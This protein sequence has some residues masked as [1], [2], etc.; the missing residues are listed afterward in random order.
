MQ[1]ASGTPNLTYISSFPRS[2]QSYAGVGQIVS[3]RAYMTIF[4]KGP[5]SG[6][7]ET[8]NPGSVVLRFREAVPCQFPKVPL[9]P[10]ILGRGQ[11]SRL[12]MGV[13]YLL[14]NNHL[15]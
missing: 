8:R 2:V 6:S 4:T 11:L 3:D 5:S 15:H 13:A 9:P 10:L 1:L 12:T 7:L 14:R